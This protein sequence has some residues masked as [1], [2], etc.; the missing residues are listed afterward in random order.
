MAEPRIL[1]IYL[2]AELRDRARSGEVGIVNRIRTAFES[3]DFRVEITSDSVAEEARSVGRNGYHLFHMHEPLGPNTLVL[4]LAY[5]YPFWRIEGTGE[6]WNFDIAKAV[7]DPAGID[8]EAARAFAARR[9]RAV[10]G[11]R[12][13]R[14]RGFILI[15]LQGRL[16]QHRSFQS[17]SP[18][19]MI[20]ATRAADPDREILLRRHPNESYGPEEAAALRDLLAATPGARLATRDTLDLLA[21]CDYVVTQNS[22]AALNG[23]LIEKP[24]VLFAKIDFHHIAGSV[25]DLGVEGAFA[26]IRGSA[27]DYA[28]YLWWF[29]RDGTIDATAEDAEDR[30]LGRARRF[31]WPV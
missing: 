9:R 18:L 28:A 14:R 4:R 12:K 10:F 11:A 5:F 2:H 7:F 17:M 16:T 21:D 30:I 3:R 1:R 29:L 25:P 31:G 13:P 19:D 22:S 23:F 24:A 6:R 26:R 15:P 8:R 20:A 27:P